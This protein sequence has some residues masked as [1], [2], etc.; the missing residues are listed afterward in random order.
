MRRP[1]ADTARSRTRPLTRGRPLAWPRRTTDGPI[2]TQ[3]R[4][5]PAGKALGTEAV[6]AA[7]FLADVL[8]AFFATLG[9]EPAPVRPLLKRL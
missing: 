6:A 4:T 7:V 2:G 5:S 1:S 8:V 3:R 9:F